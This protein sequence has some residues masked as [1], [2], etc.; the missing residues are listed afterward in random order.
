MKRSIP[1]AIFESKEALRTAKAAHEAACR[2]LEAKPRHMLDIGDPN[3]PIHDG[4]FGYET[5]SFLRKQN[6]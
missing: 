4:I 6:K 1:Q 3:H 2:E 5:E